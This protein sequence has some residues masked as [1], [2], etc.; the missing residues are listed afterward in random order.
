MSIDICFMSII[1]V[2]CHMGW[3][4]GQW[5]GDVY[6]RPFT[7]ASGGRFGFSPPG[8]VFNVSFFITISAPPEQAKNNRLG[9]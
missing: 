3:V 4:R 1:A 9:L 8:F 2:F 5:G 7:R 6:N